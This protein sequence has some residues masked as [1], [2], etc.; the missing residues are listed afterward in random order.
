MKKGIV[1]QSIR[2]GYSSVMYEDRVEF[3]KVL[4]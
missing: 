4:R 2:I 1:Q 3:D